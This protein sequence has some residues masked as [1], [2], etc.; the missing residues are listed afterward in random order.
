[1]KGGTRKLT[2]PP[3]PPPQRHHRGASAHPAVPHRGD[4]EQRLLHL[5]FRYGLHIQHPQP[6][7]L[8]LCAGECSQG[9]FKQMQLRFL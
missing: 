8:H 6:E 2:S 5:P 9:A 4:A 1:M 3:P 7:L